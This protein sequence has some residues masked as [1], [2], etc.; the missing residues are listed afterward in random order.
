MKRILQYERTDRDIVNAFLTLLQQ[1]SFEKITIADIIQEAMVNRSTFY[2]HY[3]DKY[4][5]LESIQ[6]KYLSEFMDTI[7]SIRQR[8]NLTFDLVDTL[9]EEYILEHR[10]ILSTLFKIKTEHVDMQ[11]DVREY[12]RGYFRSQYPHMKE[13]DCY[14]T[15]GMLLEF[16]NYYISE[17]N[18][19]KQFSAELYNCF[20]RLS[21]AFYQL[22]S[23]PEAREAFDAF[24]ALLH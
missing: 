14:M 9:F 17:S 4:A 21:I 22:D 15:A 10:K 20:Y 7:E 3:A 18:R 8:D 23:N 24:Q 16:F 6:N 12:L 1:K 5:L 2:Q 13:I 11:A 19:S